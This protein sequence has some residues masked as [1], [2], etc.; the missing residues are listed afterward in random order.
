MSIHQSY[1][2][3][4][5][6]CYLKYFSGQTACL[7]GW[8][9]NGDLTTVEGTGAAPDGDQDAILGMIIAVKAVEND[10]TRP[11]WYDEVRVWADESST[12]FLLS[13][14]R[15]SDSQSHRIVKLGTCWGGWEG[16]GNNPS[17]HSPG[18]YRAMRDYQ[19]AFEGRSYTLPNFGNS[20]SLEENWNMVIDTSY[21]FLE[22]TK[23]P[24]SSVVPNWALVQET[25]A[26]TL[27]KFPGS[28]SGSGTPQYEFGSEASRTMWRVVLDGIMYPDESSSHVNQFL[29][30][31]YKNMVDHFNPNPADTVTYFEE[32]TVSLI[33]K[34][35]F[36]YAIL[37][38]LSLY[39]RWKTNIVSHNCVTFSFS[40]IA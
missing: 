23:C 9:H 26:T 39:I 7:P 28:F 27:T 12:Q 4:S 20:L 16:D 3:F 22:T 8:K 30:P 10:S 37:E 32:G 11:S 34:D 19:L 14:T 35:I 36:P 2:S 17:Y 5:C 18:H 24:D 40:F 29:S 25:D 21:K 6:Q 38:F 31:L 33:K 15:L 1:L 13:N